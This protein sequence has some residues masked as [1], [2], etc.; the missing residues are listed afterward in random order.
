MKV[1][2]FLYVLG[3]VGLV[4]VFGGCAFLLTEKIDFESLPKAIDVSTANQYFTEVAIKFT[5]NPDSDFGRSYLFLDKDDGGT[6]K[7][8]NKVYVAYSK[9]FLFIGHKNT[10]DADDAPDY[11]NRGAFYI[12][13]DNGI[14]NGNGS[15]G[16]KKLKNGDSGVTGAFDFLDDVGIETIGNRKFSVYIKHYR[17]YKY[18]EPTGENFKAYRMIN[19]VIEKESVVGNSGGLSWVR[20]ITNN[21]TEI[22]I[23]WSFIFGNNPEY[24]PDKIYIEFR[25]DDG[26]AGTRFGEA[27]FGTNVTTTNIISNWLE[28]SIK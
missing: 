3:I 12:F 22:A 8:L 28:L 24:I 17:P 2:K 11:L 4:S 27:D 10:V 26:A 16:M 5:G 23:P 6:W 21:V 14:T 15:K 18:A 20:Y 1:R 9:K 19:G 13:I 25:I 7:A